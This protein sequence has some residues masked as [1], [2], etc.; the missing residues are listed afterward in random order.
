MFKK[1]LVCLDGSSLAEQIL[2]YATEEALQYNSKVVLLR[3]IDVPGTVAWIKGAPPDR[4]IVTEESHKAEKEAKAYLKRMAKLLRSRGLDVEDVVMHHI[5]ADQAI[6]DYADQNEVDLIAIT[7][8]GRS[9]LIRA[10]LGSVADSVLRTSGLPIL[11]IRPRSD[12]N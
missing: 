8:R 2:P 5:A 6:V 11:V 12:S 7:T 3:V 10:V 4:D 1:I 9:G